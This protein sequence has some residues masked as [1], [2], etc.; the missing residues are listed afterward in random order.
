VGKVRKRDDE[1]SGLGDGASPSVE[2][3]AKFG[4]IWVREQEN[5]P[6]ESSL[7]PAGHLFPGIVLSRVR[8]QTQEVGKRGGCSPV[9]QRKIQTHPYR[10]PDQYG[11]DNERLDVTGVFPNPTKARGQ[12][13]AGIAGELRG[14]D[15]E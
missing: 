15:G 5:R 6:V 8:G 12:S 14:R 7:N 4:S 11:V 3:L 1:T 9:S 10:Y 2:N 13:V